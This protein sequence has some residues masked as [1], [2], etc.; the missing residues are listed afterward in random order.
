MRIDP[1]RITVPQG[2]LEDLASRLARTRIP[3][4]N[5]GHDRG[6][7]IDPDF[8]R[9]LLQR[10]SSSFY[11]REHEARL[12][13][14]PHFLTHIGDQTIHFIHQKGVG[15]APLP[16]VLTHGWPGSFLEIERL[17]PLLTDPVANGGDPADSFHVVVPTL[18]GFGFSPASRVAEIGT[19][20]TAALWCALMNGLGYAQ[21]GVQG[22]DLGA[23]V[24]AWM[25]YRFPQQVIGMH[26]NYIPASYRPQFDNALQPLTME[27]EAF[28]KRA[29]HFLDAEGAYTRI[30]ATKPYS[31]SIGLN[32]SPAG[33]AAWI[34]EKFLAW[35]DNFEQT[36][37]METLLANISLYWFTGTIG[38]SFR[39]YVEGRKRPLALTERIAPPLGVAVFPAELPMPPRS[40]VERCFDVR[41]WSEFGVGGHFAALEQPAMLAQDIRD[42]FRPLR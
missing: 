29:G 1:F 20:E 19:Y 10:W 12:N 39:M 26:L 5:G 3:E 37:G 36:I 18:P 22:G 9:T 16:L 8:L 38:S 33:L 21:F 11:W 31:L 4:P 24:S 32:D 30:Q 23:R 42:F 15:P 41:H 17:I 27:E 35:S 14:L 2:D 40:W 28:L 7:G 25:G 13:Q 6:Q 34:A